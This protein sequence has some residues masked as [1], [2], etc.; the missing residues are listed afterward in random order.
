MGTNDLANGQSPEQI[1]A[2]V[3][4]MV[5]KA[6]GSRV[7]VCSLLPASGEAAAHLPP[8]AIRPLNERLRALAVRLRAG[9]VDLHSLVADRA[10]GFTER[11]TRDGLHPSADGYIRMTQALLPEL[12][13]QAA[14]ADSP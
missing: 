3:E 1:V 7:I 14:T 5:E 6:A 8:A 12:V 10:D 2:S 11:Y 9:Y 13:R 4:A